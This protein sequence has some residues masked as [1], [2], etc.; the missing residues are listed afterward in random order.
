[1]TLLFQRLIAS[2]LVVGLASCA[3]LI[4]KE[5]LI[6]KEQLVSTMQKQFPLHWD[7]GSGLLSIT[8]EVPQ[9]V[10]LPTPNRVGMNGHF[11]AHAA[12]ID[13]EG[14]FTAS[15]QLRYDPAQR[16]VFLQAASL[17][18]VRLKKGNNFAEMLRPQISRVLSDYAA[19]QPIYRF[20]PD[21]LV[22]LGVKVEVEGIVVTADGV[23]LKLRTLP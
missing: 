13:I 1:M 16:A 9:L 12:L 7:K 6:P 21:E 22:V 2:A 11:L 5:H 14:D 8:M 19:K 20:K 17:D 4:P 3:A 18:A 15:S 23:M 10:L